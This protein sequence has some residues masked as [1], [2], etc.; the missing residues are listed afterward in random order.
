MSYIVKQ[1]IIILHKA[2]AMTHSA[3]K[4]QHL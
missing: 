2:P 4:Y 3:G 1:Y